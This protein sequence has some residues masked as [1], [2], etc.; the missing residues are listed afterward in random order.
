MKTLPIISRSENRWGLRIICVEFIYAVIDLRSSINAFAKWLYYIQLWSSWKR[1]TELW[2][3]ESLTS[4]VLCDSCTGGRNM[5]GVYVLHV[6]LIGQFLVQGHTQITHFAWWPCRKIQ[7]GTIAVESN[8]FWRDALEYQARRTLFPRIQPKTAWV[9]NY[10]C[11]ILCIHG[12]RL[13]ASM[14]EAFSPAMQEAASTA[15]PWT[16]N[17]MTIMALLVRSRR[18]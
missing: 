7:Q 8:Q 9:Y 1:K 5:F 18:R 16:L 10:T 4:H 11:T 12:H 17:I 15:G 13:S 14:P 6:R 3:H 2:Q